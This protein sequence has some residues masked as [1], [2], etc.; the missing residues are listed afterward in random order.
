MQSKEPP[1]IAHTI[2]VNAHGVLI[3]LD[4]NVT[5]GQ[6]LVLKNL[7]TQEESPCR[8]VDLSIHDKK[9]AVA[10]EFLEPAPRFWRIAFP[11]EDWTPRNPEA[12]GH[13]PNLVHRSAK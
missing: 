10:V 4:A 12:K 7:Q 3:S 8:V 1:R 9:S 2:V 5:V 6:V 13:R 11:P